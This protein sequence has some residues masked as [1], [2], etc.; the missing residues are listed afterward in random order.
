VQK[1]GSKKMLS[2]PSVMAMIM[3]GIILLRLVC[4]MALVS[5]VVKLFTNTQY[6][7]D[8]LLAGVLVAYG[9]YF[10]RQAV[11]SWFVKNKQWLYVVAV[12]L[13]LWLPF[14]DA[15]G[16][17]FSR[18][19]GFTLLYISAS[20]VLMAFLFCQ[21]I[22]ATLDKFFTRPL[23]TAISKVGFCSY[24]IYVIH[25]L[26]INICE[27]QMVPGKWPFLICAFM[28]SIAA[29]MLMTYFVEKYFLRLRDKYFPSRA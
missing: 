27:R 22:N 2:F 9:Y 17:F 7:I 3:A 29:G 20:I 19:V 13:L 6:R 14:F 21:S 1:P 4:N 16:S 8:S 24:S 28:G 25:T 23:A 10:K 12:L 26:I 18:I 5:N 11:G 15:V